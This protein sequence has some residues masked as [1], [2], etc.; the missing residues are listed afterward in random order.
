MFSW[1]KTRL[2]DSGNDGQRYRD[3][4][5]LSGLNLNSALDAH[6]AWQHH[7]HKMVVGDDMEQAD[8][9]AVGRSDLCTLGQW[10]YGHDSQSYRLFAEYNELVKSHAKFHL[11][12]SA[13]LIAYREGNRDEGLRIL[14]DNLERLSHQVR[15]DISRLFT[16]AKN[17]QVT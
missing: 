4:E 9:G 15:Q 11:C 17:Q 14:N 6:R 8:A 16:K 2:K 10:L 5:E 1:L 7:L 3:D 13:V 12:A